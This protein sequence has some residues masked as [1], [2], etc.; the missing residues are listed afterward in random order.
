MYPVD[1]LK[2][3]LGLRDLFQQKAH[4]PQTR[5]QILKPAQGGVYTS[6]G[7]AFWKIRSVE[8]G[9]RM[10]KGVSSVIIGAGISVCSGQGT[11]TNGEV[12]PGTRLILLH[13]RNG[14]ACY[15]RQ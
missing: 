3:G 4:A 10:W 15:E 2:V 6:L 5:L 7:N 14:Q 1:M 11:Q 9:G 12:R 13:L 8:G